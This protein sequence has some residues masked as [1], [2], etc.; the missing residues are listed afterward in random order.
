M[1]RDF[2][3]KLYRFGIKVANMGITPELNFHEKK[4]T[5]LLNLLVSFS[6]PTTLFFSI[7]NLV[8]QKPLLSLINFL[9]LG[10]EILILVI[11]S[12]GK[13]FLARLILTFLA[14]ILFTISAILF[15]NGAEYL[16][17]VNLVVIIIYF[18]EKRFLISISLLN[19]LLFIGIKIFL[20]SS[21][22]YDTVPF[23]RVVFNIVWTLLAMAMA[24]LFFKNE[25]LS[26]Q[27]Q[28]EEK[29][30]DLQKMN[31]TKEKLFSIISHD[32]R[33]PIG[34]LKNL[35]QLV[36]DQQI[37]PETFQQFS[38]KLST[39]VD[40]LHSTLDNL[41]RWSISQ[42]QGIKAMPEKVDLEEMVRLKFAM[43][44][45]PAEQKNIRLIAEDLHHY[46]WAD[47]N[48]VQLVLRNLISNAIKYSYENERILV[49]SSVKDQMVIIEVNDTGMGMN[50]DVRQ[51][52]F[53][54]ENIVVSN[55]GTANERGTGLGLKL[56]K[57]FVEKN[58]GAI[59]VEST[60]E[61]GSSFFFSLPQ[62]K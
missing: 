1:F 20:D 27:E 62:A 35:L 33:S 29:N 47:P 22:I 52:I 44:K 16:L 11:N 39:E 26:Y 43:F 30:R 15:R 54:P 57:E 36:S 48:H 32:L 24:L 21:V 42:L 45:Q 38:S 37:S 61:K 19:C 2:F 34:Q 51:S 6:I 49:R 5:Q 10:G 60:N 23:G 58:N 12:Y 14:S 18:N 59:W 7:V 41:L 4:K 56:C 9:I 25:Q 28:V 50:E 3:N 40:S 55:R 8:N 53:N 17:L 13:F 46:V 31:D